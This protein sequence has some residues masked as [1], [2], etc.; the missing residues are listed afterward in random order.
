MFWAKLILVELG[1]YI[2]I[3]LLNTAIVIF[4]NISNVQLHC[5]ISTDFN[6]SEVLES[7]P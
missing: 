1:P 2:S 5:I 4:L 3:G 7:P 6:Y